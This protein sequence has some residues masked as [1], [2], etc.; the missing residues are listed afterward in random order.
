MMHCNGMSCWFHALQ[1]RRSP[2]S[3]TLL[4]HSMTSNRGMLGTKIITSVCS[5]LCKLSFSLS[6]FNQN[7]IIL[8]N[9]KGIPT[10]NFHTNPLIG[11]QVVSEIRQKDVARPV[12]ALHTHQKI[13]NRSC[14]RKEDTSYRLNE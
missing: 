14:F 3:K 4:A 6:R 9:F 8:T 10:M 7:W 12:V 13:D 2:Q 5:S 1:D 11:C